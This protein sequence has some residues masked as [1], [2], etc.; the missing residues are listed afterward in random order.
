MCVCVH[1]ACSVTLSCQRLCNPM[2]YSPSG[3][4][5]HGI[6]QA[7]ILEGL[8]FPKILEWL[9]CP[10]PGDFP[11]SGI[12]PM[13][14]VSPAWQADS[15]SLVPPGKPPTHRADTKGFRSCVPG[16]RDKDRVLFLITGTQNF[17]FYFLQLPTDLVTSKQ[18]DKFFKNL[19]GFAIISKRIS[20][21]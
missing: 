17:L 6:S 11:D 9:L 16:I 21:M 14:L 19:L 1:T 13:S 18:K 10:S 15:L 3:S 7:R 2:H 4:S 8:P 20:L 5:V 12:E